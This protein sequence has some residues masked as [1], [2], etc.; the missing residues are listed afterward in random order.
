MFPPQS[1]NYTLYD[2]CLRNFVSVALQGINLGI[3]SIGSSVSGK[4]QTLEGSKSISGVISLFMEGLFA[5][6]EEKGRIE[7]D[8]YSC[9]VKMQF[10]EILNEEVNNLI[11]HNGMGV[12]K[13]A[14]STWEGPIIE[15][16]DKWLIESSEDFNK[17]YKAG[18][19]NRKETSDD[20][21]KLSER[22]STA[23][24]LEITQTIGD[25]AQVFMSKVVFVELP[26]VE[27]LEKDK[28]VL[29]VEKSYGMYRGLF[30]LQE[31]LVAN[32]S[33]TLNNSSRKLLMESELTKL[34]SELLGG[35]ALT[36]GLFHFQYNDQ[37][38]SG[39]TMKL[40]NGL[41]QIVCFPI[42]NDNRA[43]GLLKNYRDEINDLK[44]LGSALFLIGSNER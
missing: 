34:C 22:A 28:E 19:N 15:G 30:T 13:V 10:V 26:S 38:G 37:I 2:S 18:V 42:Q 23:L 4:R 20:K 24:I 12:F 11:P 39:Y 16:M 40:L 27:I 9:A 8:S 41:K 1:D 17:I 29:K 33:E 7:T 35:N 14:M 36:I 31:F 25:N 5:G 3:L 6:I 43:I 44:S 32:A 21:G